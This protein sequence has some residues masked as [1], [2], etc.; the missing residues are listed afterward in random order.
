[1]DEAEAVLHKI[2]AGSERPHLVS[3]TDLVR[4]SLK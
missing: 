2:Q 4:A 3:D 1:M